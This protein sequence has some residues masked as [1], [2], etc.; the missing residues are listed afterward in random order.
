MT[1]KNS[2]KNKMGKALTYEEIGQVMDLSPQ[3][4]HK[5]EREAFNKILRRL[6]NSTHLSIFDTIIVLS[7]HFG[8]SLEQAYK[9]LDEENM[10]TLSEYTKENYGRGIAGVTINRNPLE[11]LFE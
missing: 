6:M 1:N 7:T 9:K 5:I 8:I 3:Q 10:Q 11:D 2:S 4:V